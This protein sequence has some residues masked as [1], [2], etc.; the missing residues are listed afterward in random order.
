MYTY[1][2]NVGPLFF[3]EFS[4]SQKFESLIVSFDG[5]FRS[6]LLESS[7]VILTPGKDLISSYFLVLRPF[8]SRVANFARH[9]FYEGNHGASLTRRFWLPSSLIIPPSIQFG[10]GMRL[11]EK[12]FGFWQGVVFMQNFWNFKAIPNTE[13]IL[14]SIQ[15]KL[16][17]K[18]FKWFLWR[19]F[20]MWW[21]LFVLIFWWKIWS[22]RSDIWLVTKGWN[23]N[24]R[25]IENRLS[26]KMWRTRSDIWLVTK[27]WNF[28]L[29]VFENRFSKHSFYLHE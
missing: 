27:R 12:R 20:Q 23:F 28:N 7:L 26:T 10:L 17:L 8:I 9:F 2:R 1:L 25:V 15:S 22:A 13:I 11:Y 6:C 5:S 18:K 14:A 19:G 3:I 21:K 29:R 4:F 24:L 16:I